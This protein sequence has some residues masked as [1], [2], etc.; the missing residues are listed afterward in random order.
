MRIMVGMLFLTSVVIHGCII[1]SNTHDNESKPHISI[2]GK[3][4]H[5]KNEQFGDYF[6]KCNKFLLSDEFSNNGCIGITIGDDT[7]N[8]SFD[9]TV[10]F[11]EEHGISCEKSPEQ[12][13]PAGVEGIGF[14]LALPVFHKHNPDYRHIDIWCPKDLAKVDIIIQWISAWSSPTLESF[15]KV[16]VI[17]EPKNTG[18]PANKH[19]FRVKAPGVVTYHD[20]EL[21]NEVGEGISKDVLFEYAF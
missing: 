8:E 4:F 17:N 19:G 5:T 12:E 11:M 2:S 9:K 10:D 6:S 18:M 3:N 14:R 15:M 1:H 7:K 21:M 16:D 20:L 13:R